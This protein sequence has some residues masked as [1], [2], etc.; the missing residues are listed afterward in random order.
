MRVIHWFRQDLRL[1]DN[2]ALHYAADQGEVIPVFI[3]LD[4]PSSPDGFFYGGA[5]RWWLHHSLVALDQN[6]QEHDQSLIIRRVASPD[7]VLACLTDLIKQSGAQMVVWNRRYEP[8]HIEQDRLIKAQLQEMGVAVHSFTGNYLFE[9]WQISNRQGK[10]YKVFTPFWKMLVSEGIDRPLTPE[11]AQ[12]RPAHHKLSPG[13]VTDLNLLPAL[14]WA[15]GFA[16]YWQPGEAGAWARVERFMRD[17]DQYD[18]T[19][20]RVDWQGTSRLSAHL[21]FGELTPRQLVRR[22]FEHNPQPLEQCGCEHFLRELGW[23]EFAAHLIYHFPHTQTDNLDP[24]FDDFNWNQDP[25]VIK[26]WQQGQTG[27]PIVDAAMRCLWHTG[28]MHNRNRMIVASFLCKNLRVHWRV[29]AD[30]FMDTLV[31]ADLASNTAGWQWV[32]GTGADAAPYFRIFNPV[33]Q[34]EKFDPNADFIRRWVPEIAALNNKQISQPDILPAQTLDQAGIVL[35]RDYPRAIV[36]IK[37]SRKAALAA[38]EQIKNR[39]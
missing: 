8:D 25:S 34:T 17:I 29:G 14:D 36:D 4:A 30:W 5:S 2:P 13:S 15:D 31:D 20:N 27:V 37:E 28:W 16:E 11:P 33:L 32:A 1:A 22:V 7:A 12:I 26:A 23:R 18:Q 9:P 10:A 24:R 39:N 3:G 35:G 38:F 21:H 19:R 6:L